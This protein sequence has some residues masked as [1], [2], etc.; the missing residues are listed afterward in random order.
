MAWKLLRLGTCLLA[1]VLTGCATA[2]PAVQEPGAA[3]AWIGGTP[4]VLVR[5]DAAQV[6]AWSQW[7]KTKDALKA[8]GKRT[9]TVWL[10]F[11]LDHLDDLPTAAETMRVVLEG[12]FP[13][14]WVGLALDWNASWRQGPEKGVWTNPEFDL[15]VS[16]PQDGLVAVRR[17]DGLPARPSPGVLR[18]LDA[19]T[20]EGS[21]VWIS[22]WDP[23]QALFGAAG[24]RLLP[25]ERLDVVLSASEE[26]WLQ[27]P[28]ILKFP[29][30]RSARAASVLLKL[31][32][33][34]I[35]GRLGQ[36]LEWTVEG[37]RILGQTLRISQ[38]DVRALAEKLVA[39]VPAP[40][41]RP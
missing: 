38:D 31:F 41:V 34:Q 5:L 1:L 19:V 3:A 4:R 14:G 40:E 10:G 25:A 18:D 15:S 23:A 32:A 2:P 9:K 36:D 11:E 20:L 35:R 16:L 12:D 28:L 30:E 7:T 8:V 26:G 22:F 17:H 24:G 39:D 27:G 33:S 6:L 37:S 13:R 29:D 21:A